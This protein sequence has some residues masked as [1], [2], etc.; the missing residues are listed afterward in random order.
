MVFDGLKKRLFKNSSKGNQK[1]EKPPILASETIRLSDDIQL[2]VKG[3]PSKLPLEKRNAI[4]ESLVR[5]TLSRLPQRGYKKGEN[6]HQGQARLKL[7]EQV[8]EIIFSLDAIRVLTALQIYQE[9]FDVINE[10]AKEGI[11]DLELAGLAADS[12]K[13]S[14]WDEV[15]SAS[16]SERHPKEEN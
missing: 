12:I 5:N 6:I 4:L 2:T 14:A 15:L 1:T 10:G 13:Q 11:Y 16:S 9:A 8:Y 7:N 3:L